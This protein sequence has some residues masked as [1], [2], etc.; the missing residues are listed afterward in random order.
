MLWVCGGIALA[1][2]ILAVIFLPRR[3][4]GAAGPVATPGAPVPGLAATA[5]AGAGESGTQRA[6]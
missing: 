1:S 2:A 6:E 3:A 5:D 4:E